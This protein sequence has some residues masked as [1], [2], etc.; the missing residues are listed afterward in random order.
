MNVGVVL[1]SYRLRAHSYIRR[2]ARA[3]H[4]T[5]SCILS[6]SFHTGCVM[7]EGDS[8]ALR[9]GGG[10]KGREEDG[11]EGGAPGAGGGGGEGKSVRMRHCGKRG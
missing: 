2:H 1:V 9:E 5:Y 6:H 4:H 10:G 7:D 8:I 11:E 3:K